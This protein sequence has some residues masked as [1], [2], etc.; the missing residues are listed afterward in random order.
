MVRAAE[1]GG[2]GESYLLGGHFCGVDDLAVLAAAAT[3]RRHARPTL[4]FWLA[5][6]GVPVLRLAAAATRGEPLYTAESL[7]ALQGG[8]LV[9]HSK[10]QRDLGFT[11]RPTVD[12]V[13]DVYRWFAA[14]GMLPAGTA[15]S[16]PAAAS[17][18]EAR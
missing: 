7:G 9:D 13:T 18:E 5:R 8:R 3:G 16:P 6:I 11:P 1:R 12:S 17:G 15:V 4:P 2:T 10:A 14:Q